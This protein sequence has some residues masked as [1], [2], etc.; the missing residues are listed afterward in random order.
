MTLAGPGA[1]R[2]RLSVVAAAAN[3]SLSVTKTAD[4]SG[5]VSVTAALPPNARGTYTLSLVGAV[6]GAVPDVLLTATS[7]LPATGLDADALTP[8]WAGG[9]MLVG[10]GALLSLLALR[11]RR[12]SAAA[13]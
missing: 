1:S 3:D 11:R 6:S 2:G 4:A 13:A 12:A 7:G 8:G 10:T 9:G 5:S